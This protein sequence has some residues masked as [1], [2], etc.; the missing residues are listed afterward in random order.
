M[1]IVFRL[2]ASAAIGLGH[3]KRCGALAEALI[4]LG[5][6]CRFLWRDLG[7]D[8]ATV[9]HN[10][11][12][13][14]TQMYASEAGESF[15]WQTDANAF[16]SSNCGRSVDW[17]IID[18]YALDRKWHEHI[19]AA[20]RCQI[21]VIDDLADRPLGGEVLIDQNYHPDHSVKYSSRLLPGTRLLGGPRYA[22]LGS[23]YA[24]ARRY[25]FS[26]KV[27]SIGLFMGGSDPANSSC[28]ALDAVDAAG[29]TA[30]VEIVSTS[31]NPH[32]ETLRTRCAARDDTRL[33]VDLPTLADF[34]A[35]HDLQIGAGGSASWERFCIGVPSIIAGFAEN[36]DQ[37]LVPL[38]EMGVAKTLSIG[39]SVA[40][41]AHCIQALVESPAERQRLCE[42]GKEMVDGA[43][44][45]RT[46]ITLTAAQLQLRQ[47]HA[48]DC[49]MAFE[50]RNHP[51]VRL[52]SRQQQPIKFADH[53][54]W[55]QQTLDSSSRQLFVGA[56]GHLAVGFIRLDE[57]E[58]DCLEVSFYLDP[59]LHGL[60]LGAC[61]LSSVE[62][63]VSP[64]TLIFGE[65]LPENQK[66]EH[67][68]RKLNYENV[69]AGRW[70][71]RI[72]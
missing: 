58:P 2:D 64:G 19:K 52:A 13:V 72:G 40:D 10:A 57:I 56:I 11:G 1:N 27:K 33:L 30:P 22:L 53:A 41:L 20:L 50:W 45:I 26:D 55:F 39:W 35:R 17:V 67:L 9:I 36:H 59:S 5:C 60:G 23:D 68:F 31:A 24:R 54:S 4:G 49:A 43:G 32:L 71:K 70:K 28:A 15:D 12:A 8:C 47:A 63:S 42:N 69:T 65:V 44:S 51:A 61:L 29:F 48:D 16:L 18:H 3:L 14:S 66:S 38:A 25:S 7:F 46:A 6:E 62:K 37:L 34:F 21:A